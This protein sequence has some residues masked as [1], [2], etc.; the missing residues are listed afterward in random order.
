ML[1]LFKQKTR[2][3]KKTRN[4]GSG[5]FDENPYVM[6]P[7]AALGLP[8]GRFSSPPGTQECARNN[9]CNMHFDRFAD[10]PH[11][12]KDAR[13]LENDRFYTHFHDLRWVPETPRNLKVA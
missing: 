10:S 9:R 6:P 4:S 11:P 2:N 12:P 3:W 1:F 8:R 5:H 7:R 13:M